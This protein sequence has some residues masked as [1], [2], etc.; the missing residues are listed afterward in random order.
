[1]IRSSF[2]NAEGNQMAKNPNFI[3]DMEDYIKNINAEAIYFTPYEGDKPQFL[4]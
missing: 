2:P 3:K 1:M 4:S